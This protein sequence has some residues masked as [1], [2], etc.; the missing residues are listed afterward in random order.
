MGIY[1]S[2]NTWLTLCAQN[3][4]P[5]AYKVRMHTHTHTHTR[6]RAHT[7]TRTHARARA[8]AREREIMRERVC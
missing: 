6:A 7:H 1:L 5:G 4:M 8:R 2:L 3:R